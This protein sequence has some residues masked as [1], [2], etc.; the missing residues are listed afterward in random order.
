[1]KKILNGAL[2]DFW[3]VLLDIVAVNASYYLAIMIRFFVNFEMN[4]AAAERYLPAFW[5]FTPCYTVLCI[6]SFGLW[7]LYGGMWIYAGLNDMNRIIGASMTTTLIQILGMLIF[8][9]RMPITYY[10]IGAL[11][12][13]LFVVLIRFSHRF[14]ALEQQKIKTNKL[15]ATNVLVVGAGETGRRVMKHLEDYS[16]YRPVAIIDIK[17]KGARAMDGVPIIEGIDKLEESIKSNVIRTV[18]IA[19][20]LISSDDRS[21]VKDICEQL[22]IELEDYTAFLSTAIGRVP[23]TGLFEL[24]RGKVT[25]YVDGKERTYDSGEAALR[26]LSG[27]YELTGLNG[28]QIVFELSRKSSH[29]YAGDE[30][31]A[32]HYQE[33]TGEDI[34]FF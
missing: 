23:L 30:T 24:T 2:R 22:G 17:G 6:V 9:V 25:V 13:F 19:D 4:P 18:F 29:S 12:Q 14:I 21:K 5:S 10:L 15:P 31:W 28:D 34:S 3:V 27:M 32:R 26:D 1:M 20:P 11:L 33:Q 7:K 8:V 16:S